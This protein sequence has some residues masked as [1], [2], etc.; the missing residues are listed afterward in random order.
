[1]KIVEK[2]VMYK[3]KICS[4]VFPTSHTRRLEFSICS[5]DGLDCVR[6]LVDHCLAGLHYKDRIH[7]TG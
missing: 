3:S 7:C 6:P 4:E 5:E 1:M 2:V